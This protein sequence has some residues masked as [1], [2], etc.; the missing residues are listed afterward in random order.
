MAENGTVSEP[1]QDIVE[2]VEERPELSQEQWEVVNKAIPWLKATMKPEIRAELEV[3]Y[4]KKNDE[5]MAQIKKDTQ[6]HVDAQFAALKKAQEPLG[7]D[8][9][10]KLLSQDYLEF[11]VPVR[12]RD[13]ENN[14]KFEVKEFVIVELPSTLEEKFYK[15]LRDALIPILQER[16]NI[17]FTLESGSL[18]D[19]VKTMLDTSE[20]ALNLGGELVAIILDPWEK[21]KS[22]NK[23]WVRDNLSTERQAAIILAQF[24][25]NKY[26]N[27]FSHGFRTFLS[28]RA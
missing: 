15:I 13:K 1:L 2:M 28:L 8:E 3:T 27:F 20:K 21:D 23:K 16:D 25:A 24:E 4:S 9:L 17:S 14:S 7:Q 5:L 22:I 18:I 10:K 11:P 19:K 26:R 6:E 12:V